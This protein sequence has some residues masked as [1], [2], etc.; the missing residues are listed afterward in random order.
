MTPEDNK[1]YDELFETFS[2]PGWKHIVEKWEGMLK[3]KDSIM[4]IPEGG[5]E[6][7]KGELRI[8]DY[9]LKFENLHRDTYDSL[10]DNNA[11][12]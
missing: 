2:T 7:R 3:A 12:L 11:N 10:V 9:M 1:Y 8:L 6:G 5:L 4:S